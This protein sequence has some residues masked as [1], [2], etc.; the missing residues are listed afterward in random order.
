VVPA[1]WRLEIVNRLTMAARRG[2]IDNDFQHAVLSGSCYLATA[3]Y[4]SVKTSNTLMNVSIN[5]RRNR[6]AG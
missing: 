2:R 5:L 4:A 1:L 6:I 3:G